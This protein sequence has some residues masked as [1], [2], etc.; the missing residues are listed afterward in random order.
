MNLFK[1]TQL[2]SIFILLNLIACSDSVLNE[3]D[4]KQQVIERLKLNN[5]WLF[6]N[7]REQLT[8]SPMPFNQDYL[9]KRHELYKLLQQFTHHSS[10]QKQLEYLIIEERFAERFYPWPPSKNVLL[11]ILDVQTRLSTL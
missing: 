9:T 7:S 1:I 8:E 5:N 4:S 2:L 6:V 3:P 10:T 11:P